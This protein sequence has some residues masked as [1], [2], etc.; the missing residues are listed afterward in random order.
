MPPV[1]PVL[2]LHHCGGRR[3]ELSG[4]RTTSVR[5]QILRAQLL[6]TELLKDTTLDATLPLLVIGGGAAGV[7]CAITAIKAGRPTLV[8]EREPDPFVTQLYALQRWIDPTEFDWPHTHWTDGHNGSVVQTPALSV[9]ANTAPN[10]V[11]D[12]RYDLAQADRAHPGLYRFEQGDANHSTIE[13]SSDHRGVV[14]VAKGQPT[15][16]VAASYCAAISCVGFSGEKTKVASS[17]GAT[18]VCP[19]FW[20]ADSIDLTELGTS[21]P[22]SSSD[23]EGRLHALVSG[24]GDG[25]MQDVQ[26]LAT[27]SMG[28]KLWFR[29]GL[30]G[31]DTAPSL[32][33]AILAEDAAR[34]AHLWS[35]HDALPIKAYEKWHG[36]YEVFVDAIWGT[37]KGRLDE[38]ATKVLRS[39][40]S[41]TW[42]IG[43]SVPGYAYGLNRLLTSLVVRLVAHR[44]HRDERSDNAPAGVR[45]TDRAVVILNRKLTLLTPASTHTCSATCFDQPHYAHFQR[46]RVAPGPDDFDA[47]RF[48][49]VVARHGIDHDPYFE[50]APITEQIVPFNFPQ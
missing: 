33:K 7:A 16:G 13:T 11:S 18:V 14:R 24:N 35:A 15:A 1:A 48:D 41:L 29:L 44:G 19:R 23:E 26:R 5:D 37:W 3:Y 40:I 9:T 46:D 34:R 43:I 38:I 47:G 25:A 50:G 45:H 49:Y 39:N 42:N 22:S 17:A 36:E 12:W 4:L 6:V 32:L 21:R 27:G 20:G 30:D 28:K 2:A 31:W 8:L 10:L